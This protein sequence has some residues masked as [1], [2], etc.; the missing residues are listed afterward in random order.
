MSLALVVIALAVGG[1]TAVWSYR[2]A[3][4]SARVLQDDILVQVASIAATSRSSSTDTRTGPTS[5]SD[6]A[7]D[8]DVATLP[9]AG[10][11]TTTPDGLSELTIG[12]RVVRAVVARRS[13]G[14]RVVVSQ[15]L[16]VRDEL[17]RQAAG[18]ALLPFAF[19]VPLL[20]GSIVVVIRLFLRPVDTLASHVRG[21]DPDDLTPVDVGTTPRELVGFL[22]ALNGQVDRVRSATDHERLFLSQAAHEL[23]TPLTAMSLQLERAARAQ[24]PS[25]TRQRLAE[26]SQGLRRTRH[27]VEQLLELARARARSVPAASTIADTPLGEVVRDVVAELLPIADAHGVEIEVASGETDGHRVP[28]P[29]TSSVLRNLLDNAIKYGAQPG[30]VLVTTRWTS[31]GLLLSV[32]DGGPGVGD[33]EKAVQAFHREPRDDRPGAFGSGLGLA[34]VTEL[35]RSVDGTLSLGPS[36]EFATGTRASA[37]IPAGPPLP[38]SRR[39]PP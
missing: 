3:L 9:A 23:R 16:A 27:V 24:D 14:S 26:L 29:V 25:A 4:E 28:G 31:T 39:P 7:T 21:R 37:T 19:L 8:I 11:P 15:P 1:A 5:P 22:E 20:L 10:V 30:T 2:N 36:Q 32:E 17:A 18:S 38:G 13:D 34:I 33:A 35:L 12:G 6:A